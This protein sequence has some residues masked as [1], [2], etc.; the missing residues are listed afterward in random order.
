MK[1]FFLKSNLVL[2]STHA[3]N[4]IFSYL[5]ILICTNFLVEE[6]RFQFTGFISLLNIFLIPISCLGISLT[7][8]YKN[9]KKNIYNYSIIYNRSL[10]VFISIVVLIL[11]LNFFFKI[12]QFIQIEGSNYKYIIALLLINFFYS[13]ENAENLARQKFLNYSVINTLPF[14]IRF[15][16][17]FIFLVY[18]GYENFELVLVIYILSFSFLIKKYFLRFKDYGSIKNIFIIKNI[19]NLNFLKNLLTISIFSIVINIDIIASRYVEPI[20]STSYYIESLFGKIIFFL[21]T[22]AVLFMYPTNVQ[23]NKK[24]FF[25][26]LILNILASFFLILFYYFFFNTFYLFLFPDMNLNLDVV[27]LISISCLLFSIS[28]LISYKL[29]IFGVYY[30]SL[31]KLFLTIILVF[32]LFDSKSIEEIIKYLIIFSFLFLIVDL[33]FYKILKKRFI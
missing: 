14:I 32:Y 20:N 25:N 26:V 17:I 4:F 30:H 18:L 33:F 7:G 3:L 24:N 5:F 28:N 19:P 16:L 2:Y 13:L 12:N 11:I 6:N 22:I 29:N 1:S 21:S 8:L 31:L 9:G 27:L 15:I 23:G 10:F